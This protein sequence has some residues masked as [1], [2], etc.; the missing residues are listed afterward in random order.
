MWV[1]VK[2]ETLLDVLLTWPTYSS[3]TWMEVNPGLWLAWQSGSRWLISPLIDL[4]IHLYFYLS[5]SIDLVVSHSSCRREW[6]FPQSMMCIWA[7]VAGY[8]VCIEMCRV[9]IW[10]MDYDRDRGWVAKASWLIGCQGG[11]QLYPTWDGLLK[12]IMMW[13]A[14]GKIWQLSSVN[15]ILFS[16]FHLVQCKNL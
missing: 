4:N 2:R 12:L 6:Y 15:L 9:V 7:D 16:L 10:G 5:A 11:T 1:L 8:N 3:D 14:I 13:T